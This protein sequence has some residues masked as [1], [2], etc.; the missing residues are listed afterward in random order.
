MNTFI[1]IC[2]YDTTQATITRFATL[3]PVFNISPHPRCHL[4]HSSFRHIYMCMHI[5]YMYTYVCIVVYKYTYVCI[6]SYIYVH[7]SP[8]PRYHLKHSSFRYIYDVCIYVYINVCIYIYI[9]VCIYLC[10]FCLYICIYA[11][12][13]S[14]IFM[15]I[16]IFLPYLPITQNTR[17]SGIV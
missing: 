1:F 15:Y 7:I 3:R 13:Y 9:T 16:Y 2:V 10:I 8:H 5:C 14:F 12:I 17:H 4:K 6:Y 11:Y